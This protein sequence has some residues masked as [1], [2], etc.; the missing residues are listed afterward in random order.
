MYKK[1]LFFYGHEIKF[2]KVARKC[3]CNH[4]FLSTEKETLGFMFYILFHDTKIKFKLGK[5][6]T[7]TLRWLVNFDDEFHFGDETEFVIKPME[8]QGYYGL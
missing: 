7:R 5:S 3:H 8:K 1:R 4:V 6:W 2:K